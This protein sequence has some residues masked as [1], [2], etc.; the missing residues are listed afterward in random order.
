MSDIELAFCENS[1]EVSDLFDRHNRYNQFLKNTYEYNDVFDGKRIKW[2][3]D[4]ESY[5]T[6]TITPIE[7]MYLIEFTTG[8]KITYLEPYGIRFRN[9]GSDH[10]SFNQLFM[11]LYNRI[12]SG[13]YDFEQVHMN[14]YIKKLKK[15]S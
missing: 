8:I 5:N 6:V 3:S 15:H 1:Q 4:D 12:I 14:E 7:D 13:E 2:V 10:A 11:K 9:S